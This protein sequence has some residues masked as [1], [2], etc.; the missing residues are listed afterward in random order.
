M[1][2]ILR[3]SQLLSRTTG[4][5]QTSFR[6]NIGVTAVVMAKAAKNADPIQN[7]FVEKLQEYKKKST[8]AGDSLVD[9]TAEMKAKMEVEKQQIRKRFGEGNLEEFPKFDFG[10]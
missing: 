7:L 10:K 6:R 8:S 2:A 3:F 4:S 1:A 5:F 9:M